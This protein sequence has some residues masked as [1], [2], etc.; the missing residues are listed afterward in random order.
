MRCK[1]QGNKIKTFM[2][3]GKMPMANCFLKKKDFKKEF[4][5]NLE[6]GFNTRNYLLQVNN[7]PK[8]NN[9]FNNKYPFYT[10]KSSYMVNHFKKYY[11]F[12]KKKYL[13]SS[14]KVVEIGSNDGSF[15]K[16][17]KNYT[18]LGFEPSSNVANFSKKYGIKVYAGFFNK[19]NVKKFK[20]FLNK[21][22]LI[23]AAN[24]ICHIPNLNDVIKSIDLLLNRKGIFVFEEPYLGS[25][26]KKISYDQIYDA[27]VFIFSIH[28][29]KSIF[30]SHGFDLID[31][32]PQKTH[33]G[34]MR[35]VIARK[36]ERKINK[37]INKL[38]KIEKKQKLN[39]LKS[40]LI[41]KKKS[42]L[43]RYK[44]KNK[45]I[46]LK[47]A[48]KTIA[49]YAASAKSCTVLNYCN[50]GTDFIDYI[51]DSTNEKIGKFSPGKHIPIVSIDY[52]KK[53]PPDYTV[54]F[55]WNH[56]KEILNKEKKYTA[57]GGKW[58]SHVEI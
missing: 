40:C 42:E 20:K 54:L 25:M 29:V 36:G 51:A 24:V 28:S 33:G 15:L 55:S 34:S 47:K 58:I 1:V 43:S 9:L 49:G 17:F 4:F 53:N 16:N 41:F 52:Y 37:S 44:F 23:C 3:F 12:L 30:N 21:T 8:S 10:N 46:S 5:Y 56:K 14:S 18:H 27:H 19:K 35:Y 11:N 13:N 22:D 57:N 31:A 32:Y 6:I 7:H 38:I 39:K 2:S 45:L 50:I 26:F 48:G